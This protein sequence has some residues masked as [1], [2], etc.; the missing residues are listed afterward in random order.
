MKRIFWK[1]SAHW[2]KLLIE[3]AAICGWPVLSEFT[4]Q[5]IEKFKNKL[6]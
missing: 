4:R 6:K 2:D 3:W 1:G 5:A